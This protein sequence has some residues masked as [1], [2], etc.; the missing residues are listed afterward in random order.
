MMNYQ[1]FCAYTQCDFRLQQ[2][3]IE[4]TYFCIGKC[5]C[6]LR[7]MGDIYPGNILTSALI[8]QRLNDLTDEGI[9]VD[10]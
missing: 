5:L 6:K 1:K 3:N 8:Q 2:N 10:E 4:K 7:Q 9:E